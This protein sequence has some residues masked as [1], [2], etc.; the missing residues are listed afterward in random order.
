VDGPTA[1]VD[2]A[3]TLA[4]AIRFRARVERDLAHSFS[5]T[6]RYF[7]WTD[8]QF[9]VTRR[10]NRAWDITAMAGRRRLDYRGA[11]APSPEGEP[12]DYLF[13]YG[14][15]VEYRLG[16]ATTVGADA[17]YYRRESELNGRTYDRLRL[18]SSIGYRF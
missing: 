15:G 14:G 9:S 18:V 3:Y 16:N 17:E 1:S 5:L 12:T 10:V 2:L 7:A 4:D 13:R 8:L 6:E 11:L